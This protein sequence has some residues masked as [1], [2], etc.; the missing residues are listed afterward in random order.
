MPRKLTSEVL[1]RE[2]LRS[3]I[4]QE[5]RLRMEVERDE[6]ARRESPEYWRWKEKILADARR[7]SEETAQ[8]EARN[9]AETATLRA[10]GHDSRRKPVR[11]GVRNR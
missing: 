6:R 2:E 1:G 4:I 9:R 8:L 7:K 3:R 11:H 5:H 10:E